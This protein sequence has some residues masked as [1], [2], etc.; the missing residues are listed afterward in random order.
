MQPRL[1]RTKRFGESSSSGG[2]RSSKSNQLPCR[3][4]YSHMPRRT[5]AL[6]TLSLR[7]RRFP[8]TTKVRHRAD[9]AAAPLSCGTARSRSFAPRL[10]GNDASRATTSLSTRFSQAR[11]RLSRRS[12]ASSEPGSEMRQRQASPTS[13]G[14]CCHISTPPI[15]P[16]S[17]VM[18]G[19]S[20]AEEGWKRSIGA[21]RPSAAGQG[22]QWAGRLMAAA[23]GCCSGSRCGAMLG[24]GSGA[25]IGNG[26]GVATSWSGGVGS[27]PSLRI[28]DCCSAERRYVR[29]ECSAE[30]SAATAHATISATT[31]RCHA[32]RRIVY[33]LGSRPAKRHRQH[34]VPCVRVPTL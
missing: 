34:G 20:A 11:T 12:G 19:S 8:L 4:P 1:R 2:S 29:V 16:C 26:N 7:S 13:A 3:L 14:R 10:P 15:A 24:G 30:M 32:A 21:T 9:E 28:D 22:G 18:A 31:S 5:A 27:A 17:A 6:R 33:P 25:G 23:A